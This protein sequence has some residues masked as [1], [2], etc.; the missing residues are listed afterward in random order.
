MEKLLLSKAV[1]SV[2]GSVDGA[3]G[4][5]HGPEGVR[6]GGGGVGRDLEL[7]K[8]RHPLL[9]L[10]ADAA[11]AQRILLWKQWSQGREQVRRRPI[12]HPNRTKGLMLER[13]CWAFA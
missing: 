9:E 10:A 11:R 3:K 1:C 12:R 13:Q 2:L 8:G 6:K 5:G 7:Q 4:L